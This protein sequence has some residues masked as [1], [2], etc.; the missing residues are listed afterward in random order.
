MSIRLQRLRKQTRR[1]ETGPVAIASQSMTR[2]YITFEEYY[3]WHIANLKEDLHSKELEKKYA[4]NLTLAQAAINEH[5]FIKE[6]AALLGVLSSDKVFALSSESKGPDFTFVT[7]PYLSVIDKTFRLNCN[8]NRN[9]PEEPHAGWIKSSNWFSKLDDLV[10][11]SLVCRYLDGPEKVCSSIAEKARKFALNVEFGP[12]ATNAGY[13]AYHCYVQVP[14][15][16]LSI[17][18]GAIISTP[19]TIEIQVTTQLQ[20]VLRDLTHPFYRAERLGRRRSPTVE[21]WDYGSAQF[22]AS[23]FSAYLASY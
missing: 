8:W 16:L 15:D 4:L 7:K 9:F 21:R 6:C 3:D 5:A 14:M 23:Y 22:K 2:K 13:Y 18:T 17:D 1:C 10:R 11:T 20:E 12:R 19:L